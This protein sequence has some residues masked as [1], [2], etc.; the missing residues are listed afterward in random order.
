M[1]LTVFVIVGLVILTVCGQVFVQRRI[2]H[3]FEPHQGVVEAMLG[4]VGTLFSVLLGLLVANAIDGYHDVKTQVSAEA[5]SLADVFRIARGFETDDRLRLR[6]LCRE[7]G[8]SVSQDEWDAMKN[9]RMS[10]KTWATYQELW[11]AVVAINPVNDRQNNLH[12]GILQAMEGLGQG[13]RSRAMACSSKL[14]PAIWIA[15]TAGAFITVIFTYFFTAKLGKLHNVMTALIAI[16]LGLNIWLLAAYS[17][18]FSGELQI[19]PDAFTLLK[20]RIFD[21]PDTPSRYL[22]DGSASKTE[23]N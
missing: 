14:Q 6:G 2:K 16:S 11:E 18:P 15:I 1:T 12:Q 9:G 7:Y 5:N 21:N 10:D 4:V 8:D 20:T 23:S 22:H 17:S 3:D 13:R 19:Q